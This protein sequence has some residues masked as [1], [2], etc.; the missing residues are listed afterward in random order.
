MSETVISELLAAMKP[1][2]AISDRKHDAWDAAKA[3]MAKAESHIA[4]GG[5]NRPGDGEVIELGPHTNMTAAECLQYSAR[6][7]QHYQ[8][9]I[10]VGLDA[11]GAVFLRSSR[12]TREF[13]VFVLLEALDKARGLSRS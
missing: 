10:V 7:S 13:A 5:E 12:L 6:E 4:A 9:V 1:V 11:D 3:A 2:I 8:D